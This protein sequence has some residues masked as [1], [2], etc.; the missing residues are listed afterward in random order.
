MGAVARTRKALW[1]WVALAAVVIAGLAAVAVWRRFDIATSYMEGSGV[2]REQAIQL[3]QTE[4]EPAVRRDLRMNDL[5]KL[6]VQVTGLRS[7]RQ[8]QDDA[9]IDIRKYAEWNFRNHWLFYRSAH[10]ADTIDGYDVSGY[11]FALCWN[12]GEKEEVLSAFNVNFP[13]RT[14]LNRKIN[15]RCGYFAGLKQYI[16]KNALAN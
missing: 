1:I 7:E 8:R 15:F 3:M 2:V 12:R 5:E 10:N 6:F 11:D 13:A 16:E 4:A 14:L 9:L